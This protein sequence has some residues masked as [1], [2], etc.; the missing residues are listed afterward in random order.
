MYYN[1]LNLVKTTKVWYAISPPITL[2]PIFLLHN[3]SHER[4]F[5]NSHRS[6]LIPSSVFMAV[7]GGIMIGTWPSLLINVSEW[8]ISTTAAIIGVHSQC[9]RYY[10]LIH[11]FDLEHF[12]CRLHPRSFPSQYLSITSKFCDLQ[13]FSQ[14]CPTYVG[15]YAIHFYSSSTYPTNYSSKMNIGLQ[16]Y[17]TQYWQQWYC[18]LAQ[19][20]SYGVAWLWMNIWMKK[21]RR[22]F[23]DEF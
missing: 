15:Q 9:H 6:M 1:I 19:Q 16:S 10:Y 7:D 21:S 11:F 20:C 4:F 22:M 2:P 18:F 13:W 5:W 12:L 8:D 23:Y 17:T 3:T 14:L